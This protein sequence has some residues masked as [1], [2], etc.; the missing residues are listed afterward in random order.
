MK[1]EKVVITLKRRFENLN[2]FYL[3]PNEPTI[4]RKIC[5]EDKIFYATQNCLIEE[6]D[7]DTVQLIH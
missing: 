1:N 7:I 5:I 4:A 2:G 6:E 3:E